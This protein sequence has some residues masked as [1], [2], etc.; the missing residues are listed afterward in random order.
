MEIENVIGQFV[1]DLTRLG[2]DH[3]AAQV[4]YHRVCDHCRNGNLRAFALTLPCCGRI[5]CG[6]C[7]A[8]AS[9]YRWEKRYLIVCDD[10]RTAHTFELP[11]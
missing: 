8:R 5:L 9:V 2:A 3:L 11:R 7:T 6:P 4:G 10:C 1:K